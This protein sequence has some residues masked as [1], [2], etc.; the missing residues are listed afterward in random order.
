[1]RTEITS[2]GAAPRARE[3]SASPVRVAFMG[4]PEFAVPSLRALLAH[5]G[6]G[7]HSLQLVVV[8]TQPDRPAGRGG[9]LRTSPVKAVAASEGIPVLQPER[10]RRPESV[11]ALRAYL[12]DLVVVA[13]FAQILPPNVL[14]LPAYGCLNVHAS[15]LPLW[16]GASPVAAAIMA[17]DSTTGVTIMQMDAG[18]DT[19]PILAQRV[20][21][22]RPDDTTATLTDHLAN[23]GAD[24]LIE[25]LGPWLAGALSATPQDDSQATVSRQ[26]QREDGRINWAGF[27][28]ATIARTVRAF[29]PWPG[30]FTT[31]SGRLIKILQA[32]AIVDWTVTPPGLVLTRE[33]SKPALDALGLRWPQLM[34]ACAE[35]VLLAQ[36]V[37]PH[38]RRPMSGDEFM[39]GQRGLPGALV[40][41]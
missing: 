15:L 39:R 40:G 35:G 25:S 23:L 9:R 37:Q 13:A 16:R 4:T 8:V 41:T 38:A 27:P 34:I 19:G 31:I 6:A 28:A 2:G 1:M 33:Q 20:A 18:L 5:S 24:L 26:L 30:T 14:E 10:L 17:G 21:P 3:D 22:I 11:E 7:K 12:P 29:D 36:R 32:N